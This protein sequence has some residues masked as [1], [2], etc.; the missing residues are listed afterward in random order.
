M[1]VLCITQKPKYSKFSSI[2][3]YVRCM[4]SRLLR[5]LD[6]PLVEVTLPFLVE[7]LQVNYIHFPWNLFCEDLGKQTHLVYS[8]ANTFDD[9]RTDHD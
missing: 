3:H 6:A 8:E 1:G 7:L 4:P 5:R 9:T 2:Q